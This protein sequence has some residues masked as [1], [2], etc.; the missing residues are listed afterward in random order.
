MN[1]VFSAALVM[2]VTAVAI[3]DNPRFHGATAFAIY[4]AWFLVALGMVWALHQHLEK[5]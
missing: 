2:A 4:S 3:D 5:K 1:P